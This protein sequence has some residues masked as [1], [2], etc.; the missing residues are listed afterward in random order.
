ILSEVDQIE[1]VPFLVSHLD[2]LGLRDI[3]E[4]AIVSVDG[5]SMEPTAP[6]GSFALIDRSSK[7]LADGVYAIAVDDLLRIKRLRKRVTGEVDILSDNTLYS[8]ETIQGEDLNQLRI[9][10]RVRW[11]GKWL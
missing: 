4:L 6:N 8:P 1:D 9:I 10:G 2:Q 11:I 3:R 7:T 5:D